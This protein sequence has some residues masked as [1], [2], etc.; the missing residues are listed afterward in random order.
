MDV[1]LIIRRLPGKDS[2]WP[3]ATALDRLL[4]RSTWKWGVSSQFLC[5]IM[6]QG[7]SRGLGKLAREK[8]EHGYH[9]SCDCG[10]LCSIPGRPRVAYNSTK[11]Y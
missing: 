9:F 1:C 7:H 3:K 2:A 11:V 10:P 4:E 5:D 8:L 6:S